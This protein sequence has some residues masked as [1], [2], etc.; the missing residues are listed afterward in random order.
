MQGPITRSGPGDRGAV[1]LSRGAGRSIVALRRTSCRA[2]AA[3]GI[4]GLRTTGLATVGLTASGVA[5]AG[6]AT[7]G[8]SSPRL[9]ATT[10]SPRAIAHHGVDRELHTEDPPHGVGQI[11]RGGATAERSHQALGA[12]T[13]HQRGA[14]NGVHLSVL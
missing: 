11:L 2:V 1:G 7:A 13:K 10:G 4:V 5:A 14:L 3:R 9:F 8:G 6:L 12:E